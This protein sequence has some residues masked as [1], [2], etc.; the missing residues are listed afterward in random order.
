MFWIIGSGFWA[1]P[2]EMSLLPLVRAPQMIQDKDLIP[3]RPPRSN[4]AGTLDVVASGIQLSVKLLTGKAI[5]LDV[6]LSDSAKNVKTWTMDMRGIPPHHQRLASGMPLAVKW[7][8]GKA[9]TLDVEP[10]DT[11]DNAKTLALGHERNPSS[12]AAVGCRGTRRHLG[13]RS[14]WH[15]VG[16]QE[17]R[18]QGHHLGRRA[19]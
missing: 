4:V 10:S 17:A 16:R 3:P 8:A 5:T 18:R 15:A 14:F 1:T 6:E 19:I 7:L 9:I 13:R 12:P 11:A 2:K